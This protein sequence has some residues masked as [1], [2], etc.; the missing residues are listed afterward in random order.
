[1]NKRHI[2]GI[3]VLYHVPAYGQVANTVVDNYSAFKRYS[4]FPVW[5]I[6]TEYGFPKELSNFSFDVIVLHYSLFGRG[7][8][9]E[10]TD[11]FYEY[12][13][14]SRNSHIISFFQDEYRYCKKRF[15]FIDEF[16]IQTIYTCL[17]NQF[18]DKV[19]AG[20][21]SAR[22]IHSYLPGYVSESLISEAGQYY[23]PMENRTIDIGYRARR[24]DFYMGAGAQEK[25]EIGTRFAGL[26]KKRNIPLHLDID[27]E[28]ES[29]LYGKDWS[30][31]L[32]NCRGTLGVESGISI[33]DV[34]D[35][36]RISCENMIQQN[37]AI[38]FEEIHE[39]VLKPWENNIYLRTI[40]PRH[41]EGAAFRV[42]QI[43][44]EGKYSGIMKPHVHY[45]PMK[46]DFS[47]FDE[48][49][50]S[51][52][53]PRIRN[54]IVENAYTDL[55]AQSAYSYKSFIR[56][57]DDRLTQI[58]LASDKKHYTDDVQKSLDND[59]HVRRIK[60][61]MR[62]SIYIDFPGRSWLRK[63]LRKYIR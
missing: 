49:I 5:Q 39:K 38:T 21:T 44:F 31:F 23:K 50:S 17:E 14:A 40:S 28:D 58:G 63:V 25:H 9:Y 10:L 48:V 45:I 46:K 33:F 2:S 47:N 54:V 8:E 35:E 12:L 3:L 19:Y 16:N 20:Y 27:V 13:H 36:V 62:N 53:D 55:I 56:D 34:T 11:E 6:N 1:M 30:G 59:L 24:L 42:C 18:F 57:F 4:R 22:Y 52:T 60:T 41:F 29:R 7:Y 15:S 43:L 26:V 32:S 51:F 37:P 61:L